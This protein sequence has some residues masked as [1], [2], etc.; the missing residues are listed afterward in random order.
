MQCR[1]VLFSHVKQNNDLHSHRRDNL[2]SHTV[3]GSQLFQTRQE[4]CSSRARLK[5][6]CVTVLWLLKGIWAERANRNQNVKP[7]ILLG[8]KKVFS[9][10]EEEEMAT[11]L[12]IS[13]SSWYRMAKIS[14]AGTGWFCGFVSR[15][16]LFLK[17]KDPTSRLCSG[18]QKGC[19]NQ[20][21]PIQK[22]SCLVFYWAP[23]LEEVKLLWRYTSEHI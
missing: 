6:Q 4:I 22:L 1:S 17:K 3:N 14:D 19:C 12:Q 23:R 9:T 5:T 20:V 21:P 8:L 18:V 11:Q 10:S 2:M 15:R 13:L 16:D 7:K